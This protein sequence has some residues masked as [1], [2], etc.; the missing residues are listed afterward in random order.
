VT[1]AFGKIKYQGELKKNLILVAAQEQFS[2]Q[3][4]EQRS[5][6]KKEIVSKVLTGIYS[7]LEP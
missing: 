2:S 3:Q 7:M 4:K 5:T 6:T 1:E